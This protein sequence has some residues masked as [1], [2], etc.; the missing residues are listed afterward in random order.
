ML[1]NNFYENLP[2][3]ETDRLIL[4]K[5]IQNDAYDWAE[6]TADTEINKHW[7]KDSDGDEINT[8]SMFAEVQHKNFGKEQLL[9]GIALKENDKLIGD[10][11]IYNIENSRMAKVAFKI[12]KKHW[13]NS[14][15]T[16]A[17]QAVI[18]FCFTKTELQR[19]W[20]DVTKENIASCRVL[21][22]CGFKR[23]GLIRQ[24]KMVL[25]Y[26]DYYIYGIIKDDFIAE[27]L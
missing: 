7:G 9:W 19:I 23:E 3:L 20:S 18:K 10:I 5:I 16:E 13:G 27:Q 17:L 21:E 24:G 15:T 1:L 8:R 12:A 26:C 25:S 6:F 4:R 2:K 11:Q 14:Y 22:K